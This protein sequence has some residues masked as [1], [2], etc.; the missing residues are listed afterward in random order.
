MPYAEELYYYAYHEEDTERLPVV[1]IHGAGGDH[2]HWPVELRRLPEYRVYALDLPGHGKSGGHGL[3]RIG[4]YCEQVI[5]WMEAIRLYQAVFVGHSMGGGIALD[6]TLK[7]PEHVLGLGLIAT[8]AQ[9]PVHETLLED[10]SHASTFPSAVEQIMEWA[11]HPQTGASITEAAQKEMLK[12]RPTVLHGDFQACITFDVRDQV[13]TIQ[14]LTQVICGKED[15]M[16]P[17]RMSQYL[18]DQIPNADLTIIP[19]AGHMV[20]LEQAGAVQEALEGFLA[21]IHS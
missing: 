18:A 16:T 5:A 20:M 15:R 1:L 17:L 9:L 19:E 7:H 13:E 2:M 11:F 14:K 4:D 21:G 12:T 10:T 3:Q 8:G 6:L